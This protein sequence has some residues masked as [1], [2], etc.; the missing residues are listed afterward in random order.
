[1]TFHLA[2][3]I[4]KRT[5]KGII[6]IFDLIRSLFFRPKR[7]NR[8]YPSARSKPM[9]STSTEVRASHLLVESQ[10]MAEEC[11]SEILAGTSFDAVAQKVSKCPSGSRGGDLGYFGRG[12]MVPQFE[13]VAFELPVGELS[14][15][16]Q[17]QFG[18]HL[19]TVTD[20]R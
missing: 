2:W 18:W 17:T 19:I 1:L 4:V 3:K 10:K 13:K 11:R 7:V 5:P 16:V 8:D 12:Q 15:P 6:V 14:D 20:R 9:N